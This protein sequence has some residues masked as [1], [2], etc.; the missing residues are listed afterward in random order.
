[1]QKILINQYKRQD[2]FK[3]SHQAHFRFEKS[4][5]VY[6][7]LKDKRCFPVGCIWFKWKCRLLNKG[8]SCPKGY[9]HV[10]R[11]C[12]SCKNYFEEKIQYQ[13]EV[14]LSPDEYKKFQRDLEEFEE[15]L[16]RTI[17]RWMEFSGKVH[18]VKPH[19]RKVV[20]GAKEIL[21]F[22]GYLI[23]FREGYLD[24]IFFR[25]AIFVTVSRRTQLNLKFSKG[26]EVEFKARLRTDKGRIILD[27]IKYVEFPH[28]EEADTWSQGQAL[29]ARS[30]GTELDCQPEKC[31]LCDNGSLLDVVEKHGDKSI[32]RRHLFCLAGMEDPEACVY[33][34]AKKIKEYKQSRYLS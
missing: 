28:K 6:H 24:R 18:S 11:D 3:C 7:V 23:S 21:E 33:H 14:I 25:D 19:F 16:E 32:V 10:G 9:K 29:V 20:Y 30:T 4:V 5:S 26:D 13:P 17:G 15:W 1:M 8:Q 2:V 27:R 12:F 22:P 34:L 31:M